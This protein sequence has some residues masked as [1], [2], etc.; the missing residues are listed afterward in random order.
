MNNVNLIPNTVK[1]FVP[2][3]PLQ[4]QDYERTPED[5]EKDRS[6]AAWKAQ[7]NQE[8]MRNFLKRHPSGRPPRLN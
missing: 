3:K 2:L 7:R 4:M 8:A 5:E 1:A 6:E